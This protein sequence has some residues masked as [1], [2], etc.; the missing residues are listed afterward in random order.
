MTHRIIP[1][2][3]VVVF[4]AVAAAAAQRQA[5]TVVEVY[6]TP[7]CGCC[8]LWVEHLRADGFAVRV[9]DMD[10]LTEMK[11]SR[12]VPAQVRS[13][14]T[15]L[16]GGYVLE[17]HV[18]VAD[19][20]RLLKEKPAVLGLA[21]PGMPIGSPGMEVRGMKPQPFDVFTFDR[22]GKTSVFA[23]HNK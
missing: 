19:V 7:T 12:K 10:D 3:L 17:G 16:V 8:A 9:T 5:S 20:R 1:P 21:V 6:K 11:A 2:L 14:H 18:P 4:A 13:C 15:A 22:Q 23:A